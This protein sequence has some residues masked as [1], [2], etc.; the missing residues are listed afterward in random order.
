MRPSLRLAVFSL[1]ACYVV[2]KDGALPD[3][4]GML[5]QPSQQRHRFVGVLVVV[6]VRDRFRSGHFVPKNRV[7]FRRGFRFA[8]I[9]QSYVQ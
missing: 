6:Q 5:Y 7:A 9:F 2:R 4:A 3:S 1:R 8:Q